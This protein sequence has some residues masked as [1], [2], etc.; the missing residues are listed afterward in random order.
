MS[1]R[2]MF[3]WEEPARRGAALP[4][5]LTLADQMAYT[6]LRN[7]YWSFREKRIGREQASREKRALRREWEKA[8]KAEIGRAHV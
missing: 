7:I 6:T 4:E 2:W 3:P 5:E 8:K 1:E